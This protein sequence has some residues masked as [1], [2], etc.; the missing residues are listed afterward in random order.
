MGAF[1]GGA[2]GRGYRAVTLEA[3]SGRYRYFGE[4]SEID[5]DTALVLHEVPPRADPPADCLRRAG[6]DE[7][8]DATIFVA[9]VEP[10]G[11]G[12]SSAYRC[13][14]VSAPVCAPSPGS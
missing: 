5:E 13:R 9:G 14:P 2:L 4:V 8:T 6:D 1:L 7:P 3:T 11:A 10:I 12:P